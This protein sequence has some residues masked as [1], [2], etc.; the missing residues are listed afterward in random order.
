[1]RIIR[2][3]CINENIVK[4]RKCDSIFAYSEDDI[5]NNWVGCEIISPC[6]HTKGALWEY[7]DID[8]EELFEKIKKLIEEGTK[9]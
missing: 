9:R 7:D 2:N 4:C 1:M 5:I 8:E 3:N 6:C